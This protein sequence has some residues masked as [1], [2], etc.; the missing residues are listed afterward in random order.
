MEFLPDGRLLICDKSGTIYLVKGT[1]LQTFGSIQVD[2]GGERGLL[3]IAV[4]PNFATN[5]RF[6]LHYSVSGGNKGRVSRF[7]ANGDTFAASTE[8]I[9][10]ETSPYTSANQHAGGAVHVAQDG[11]ILVAIGDAETP[12]LS[13]DLTSSHGKMLRVNPDGSGIPANNPFAGDA[14]QFKRAI[15]ASGLRN[16]F[17]FAVQPGT[18]LT[19]ID[20]VGADAYEEIDEL[21]AGGNYGWPITGDRPTVD[22]RF[23]SPVF[24]YQHG[25]GETRGCSIIGGT[26][27][28][29]KNVTFPAQYAGKFFFADYCNGWIRSMDPVTK[30]VTTFATGLGTE[31]IDMKVNPVDGRLYYLK[32]DGAAANTV[33]AIGFAPTAPSIATQPADQKIVQGEAVT[34]SCDVN[35]T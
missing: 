32:L 29:P 10:L 34:F 18:G 31:F 19:Y 26:F 24:S 12:T 22:A 35:G 33:R 27:Y 16:P 25:D 11:T 28:N 7:T 14:N 3:G 8:L 2:Q 4:D 9:L 6:Y 20:D 5:Q 15:Y 21:V 1:T 17:T 13:Q 23:K 30:D